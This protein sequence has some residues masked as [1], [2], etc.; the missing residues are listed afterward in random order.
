VQGGGKWRERVSGESGQV[1]RVVIS[2]ERGGE[3][4]ERV[5]A[6]RG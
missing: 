4:R 5:S 1:E 2:L 3:C 6:E